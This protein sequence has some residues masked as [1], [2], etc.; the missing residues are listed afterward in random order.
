[1][2]D[3]LKVTWPG[4]VAV[5]VLA[6]QIPQ[7]IIGWVNAGAIATIVAGI[8]VVARYRAALEASEK[9]ATA[10]VRER[11]AEHERAERLQGD[12]AERDVELAKVKA[13]LESRP[14]LE[15]HQRLLERMLE[16]SESH[17][18]SGQRRD[19]LLVA[20]LT[21]V[22]S[23]LDLIRIAVVPPERALDD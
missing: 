15:A 16:R 4:V 10:V 11:D 13:E 23:S 3:L 18:A 19:E 9:S 2:L 7:G 6:Q 12:I 14:D 20:T 8:F 22:S 1:M 17:A 5:G 21:A